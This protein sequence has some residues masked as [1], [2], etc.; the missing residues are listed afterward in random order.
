M[1][2]QVT[3]TIKLDLSALEDIESNK[4]QLEDALSAAPTRNRKT[5]C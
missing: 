2:G 4:F 3:L 5:Q 1:S